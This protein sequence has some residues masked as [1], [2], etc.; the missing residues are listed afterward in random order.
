MW[1]I[2][3]K[4]LLILSSFLSLVF[5]FSVEKFL[6]FNNDQITNFSVFLEFLNRSNNS[7]NLISNFDFLLFCSNV[8]R[9][10]ISYFNLLIESC[11]PLS[12]LY[13]LSSFNYFYTSSSGL[14]YIIHPLFIPFL[15]L[16]YPGLSMY[17]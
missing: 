17:K 12:N 1:I 4:K 3:L 14:V 13:S 15:F 7:T 11:L 5:V 2:F 10:F 9:Q 6:S 16:F 8:I